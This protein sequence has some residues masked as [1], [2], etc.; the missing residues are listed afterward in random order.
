MDDS[1]EY[2]ETIHRAITMLRQ[3]L[4]Q[5]TSDDPSRAE[6]YGMLLW[7]YRE[8]LA[9]LGQRIAAYRAARRNTTLTL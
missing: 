8:A 1:R 6:L 3:E 5:M 9:F 2:Y 7:C 4:E